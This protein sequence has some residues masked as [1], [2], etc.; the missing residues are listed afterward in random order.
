MDHIRKHEAFL[1]VL[2]IADPNLR[3]VILQKCPDDVI[4]ALVE[5]IINLL[6]GNI[7]L[8]PQQKK[9]LSKYKTKFRNISLHSMKN[10]KLI[11]K[12]K[13][14]KN[15]I[16]VGGALPFLIPL[17]APLIA[18]AALGGVVAAGAGVATKKILGE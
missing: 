15:L 5:I 10:N 9:Q 2:K 7:N 11:N 12:P 3:K 17:L 4:C 18:K 1:D 14:R 16:Q 13:T 8:T 6:Q